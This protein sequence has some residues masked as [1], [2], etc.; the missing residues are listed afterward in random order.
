MS[1]NARSRGVRHAVLPFLKWPLWDFF[2][3]AETEEDPALRSALQRGRHSIRMLRYW[4]AVNAIRDEARRLGRPPVVVDVG[5]GRGWL[6]RLADRFVSAEWI[7]LDGRIDHDELPAA[8]YAALRQCDFE[9]HLPVDTG[10]ADIVVSLHVFEHLHAPDRTMAEIRRVLR[11][12]GVFLGGT[13]TMPAPLALVRTLWHQF[14]HAIGRPGRNGHARSFS[15]ASWQRLLDDHGF[16]VEF[17][18][19]SHFYRASRSRMESWPWWVRLNQVLGGLVPSL[20]SEVYLMAVR[21]AAE[22]P[23]RSRP[24]TWFWRYADWTIPAGAVAVVAALLLSPGEL[25]ARRDIED[26]L[27]AH[28]DHDDYYVLCSLAE[29]HHSIGLHLPIV[30]GSLAQEMSE[31]LHPA[32]PNDVHVVIEHEDAAHWAH[33]HADGAWNVVD[34]FESERGRLL[35]L[36]QREPGTAL[37]D[38]MTPA[39]IR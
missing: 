37:H 17:M 34:T 23:R 19:G 2:K 9:Q 32:G 38:H 18:T 12:G 22:R 14:R 16:R 31:R 6:K 4:W 21:L 39:A 26:W 35:L 20:G 36:S 24:G 1:R 5:C 25:S 10:Q 15:P 3:L 13:P 28:R 8:G 33:T 11:P 27:A 29:D 30:S 7:G